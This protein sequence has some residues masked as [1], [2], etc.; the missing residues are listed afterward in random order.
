MPPALSHGDDRGGSAVAECPDLLGAAAML[1]TAGE[2]QQTHQDQDQH[3]QQHPPSGVAHLHH[4][5]LL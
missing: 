5:L 4:P 1:R 2:R 3:D